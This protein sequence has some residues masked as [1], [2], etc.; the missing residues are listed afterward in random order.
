MD[1]NP[2]ASLLESLARDTHAPLD[3]VLALF[4]RER[5]AL[6]REATVPNYINLLAARRVRKQ[7]L[8]GGEH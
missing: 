6:A 8:S 1:Q 3:E 7:L 4:E 2:D 5:D